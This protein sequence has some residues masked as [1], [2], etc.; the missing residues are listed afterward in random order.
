MNQQ[1]LAALDDVSAETRELS[2]AAM[3]ERVQL[4]S[5]LRGGPPGTVD[6][7]LA[8]LEEIK[9]ML[10][11]QAD[12]SLYLALS[13]LR[14]RHAQVTAQPGPAPEQH[15]ITPFELR[16]F[17]QNGEDGAL[18]EILR[19]TGAPT[20]FF[21]EFG[22]ES[23]TEGNCVYLADVAGWH[24]LLMEADDDMYGKLERK[25]AGQPVVQT[26]Q[27]M[28]T[29]ENIEELLRG[30][31][32]RPSPMSFRSTSMARTTGS[33]KRF[34]AFGP[35]V[36]IVEYNSA[37]DPRR[38]LVQPRDRDRPWDGTDYFG[39]SLGALRSL[40][41][42]KG[43]RLV[44][45]ELS[46][47]N[48]FFVRADLGERAFPRRRTWRYEACPTTFRPGTATRPLLQT[49]VSTWTSTRGSD[50]TGRRCLSTSLR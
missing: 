38:R 11:L 47:V 23:G 44:H 41:D 21:V 4:V 2:R 26:A 19:R 25:Y 10:K 8:S 40:A 1:V 42:T 20:R 13:E 32:C 29:P 35:R 12:R 22:V 46:G 17:S 39:A 49:R 24:G 5:D 28:V 6:G 31:P 45:T 27:A 30:A 14:E 3:A 16:V 18:A 48:A 9:Q 33:G 50:R 7:E 43:Y 34:R 15:A 37:L 36:V